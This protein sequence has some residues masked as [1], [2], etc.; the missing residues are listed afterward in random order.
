[1]RGRSLFARTR[2]VVA[3]LAIGITG[4]LVPSAAPASAAS[5]AATLTVWGDTAYRNPDS[6]AP[7]VFCFGTDVPSLNRVVYSADH[8]CPRAFPYPPLPGTGLRN[9]S[10]NDCIS[11]FTFTASCHYR[12]RMY[13]DD[14]YGSTFRGP[15][16][17]Q[18]G[19]V[20]VAKMSDLGANDQVS[21]IR[22]AYRP[23]CPR[24]NET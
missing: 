14:D 9:T 6:V 21:S 16:I 12:V 2:A 17:F 20:K 8:L 24:P 4:V 11:S 15:W 18:W 23:T 3:A 1:M 13:E 19:S 5:C 10:W 22:F 7:R